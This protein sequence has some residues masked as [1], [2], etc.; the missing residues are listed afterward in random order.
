[1]KKS[2]IIGKKFGRL[3]TL[4]RSS[5]R[6]KNSYDTKYLCLCDCGTIKI[7]SYSN[8][9]SGTTKSCGCLA[10]DLLRKRN[11][12]GTGD[13]CRRAIWNYYTRNAKTRH[14]KWG[15]SYD[16]FK[17]II[18]QPCHYCGDLAGTLT[19]MRHGDFLKHNGIDRFH[20]DLGYVKNN[21]IP[22]CK[23]CNI[24][25][26]D[27]SPQNFEEWV[28]TVYSHLFEGNL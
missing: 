10:K 1:M 14:I 5:V 18:E 4:E 20:N 17:K 9:K 28:I 3:T 11:K 15:L 12:K 24:A 22:C 16:S 2:T 13:T 21:C 27:M 7:I 19:K 25:K 26:G 6:G 8:L 23:R